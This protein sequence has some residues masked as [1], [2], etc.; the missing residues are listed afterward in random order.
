M[1]RLMFAAL[2]AAALIFDHMVA[3]AD[4]SV[5]PMTNENPRDTV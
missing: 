5:E 3:I 2:A 4:K 1:R